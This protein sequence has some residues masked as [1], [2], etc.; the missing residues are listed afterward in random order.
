M[1]SFSGRNAATL[2][3][4]RRAS[5]P[6]QRRANARETVGLHFGMGLPQSPRAKRILSSAWSQSDGGRASGKLSKSPML[7]APLPRIRFIK[8]RVR[9]A[10]SPPDASHPPNNR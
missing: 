10:H 3:T 4:V 1:K 6:K 7:P 8:P 2:N 9:I 5:S